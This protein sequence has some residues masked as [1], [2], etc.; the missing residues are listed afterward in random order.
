MPVAL[1]LLLPVSTILMVCS[2]LERPVFSY[3]LTL[4]AAERHFFH[5]YRYAGLCELEL[6]RRAALVNVEIVNV[7]F[8]KLKS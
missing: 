3:T 6:R 7:L 4:F 5:V 8:F 1:G 2:P